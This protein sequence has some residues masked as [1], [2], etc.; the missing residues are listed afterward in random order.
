MV[1]L[2]SVAAPVPSRVETDLAQVSTSLSAALG[3]TLRAVLLLGGYGRGE[4]G[5]VERNG[6]LGPFND[7]DVVV[8]VER[9][10]PGLRRRLEALGRQLGGTIGVDVDLHAIGRRRLER[11]P[12]TLLWLD[13]ALGAVRVLAGDPGVLAGLE[14]LTPRRVPLAEGGRLLANRATGLALSNLEAGSEPRVRAARHAHKAVLACGDVLLLAVDHYAATMTAR[15]ERLEALEGA[16]A[17]DA[18]L[19]AAYREALRFRER[20][21]RWVPH[22]GDFRRWYAS[23]C[24]DVGR[25]HLAF[26][27]WRVGTPRSVLGFAAFSGR[28]YRDADDLRPALAVLAH[29]R[30]SLRGAA[31]VWPYLGHPRERLARV[32]VALAY[33]EGQP[34]CRTAAARLLGLSESTDAV[35][36]KRLVRL[37]SEAA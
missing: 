17:I 20:P 24:R 37:V 12:R 22:D 16:P 9:T 8:V 19:V 29:L 6:E 2:E 35:L 25:R 13:A 18:G 36:R 21:D 32:A 15:L 10:G 1:S 3:P 31:P 33:G 27:S 30:A 7:Y 23:T 34:G 28:L 5:L 26:E 14:R 4:G 11:P